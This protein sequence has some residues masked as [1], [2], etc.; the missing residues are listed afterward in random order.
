MRLEWTSYIVWAKCF[1]HFFCLGFGFFQVASIM[2]YGGLVLP[3]QLVGFYSIY[4]STM[5]F[6][7]VLITSPLVG[8]FSNY[9]SQW[10]KT[11]IQLNQVFYEGFTLFLH[12]IWKHCLL[13]VMHVVWSYI[14]ASSETHVDFGCFLYVF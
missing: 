3:S 4:I 7:C 1:V 14:H 8:V 10:W 5:Q 6:Y 9:V 13:L 12:C 2:H 11:H